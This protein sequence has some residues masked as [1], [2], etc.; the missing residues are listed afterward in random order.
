MLVWPAAGS[1]WAEPALER[2]P[3]SP[4]ISSSS[5]TVWEAVDFEAPYVLP[6]RPAADGL[7]L[8]YAVG[9]LYGHRGPW[10][11]W[12]TRDALVV[13]AVGTVVIEEP[14]VLYSATGA[15]PSVLDSAW[16]TS[17]DGVGRAAAAWSALTGATAVRARLGPSPPLATMKRS[18]QRSATGGGA[19]SVWMSAG[20]SGQRS[21][22]SV[23]R[24]KLM[25]SR[26]LST[27]GI[28]LDW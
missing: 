7:G 26:V 19:M 10:R 12:P 1:M 27:R 9:F 6:G 28:R 14:V 24:I 23:S 22:I 3:A 25:V 4:L 21:R 8:V 17:H 2:V 18:S 5:E 16:L 15:C 11:P 13:V 20:R